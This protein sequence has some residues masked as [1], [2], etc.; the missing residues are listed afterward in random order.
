MRFA[1]TGGSSCTPMDAHTLELLEFAKIR[2]MVAARAACSLGQAA[3]LRVEPS[4]DLG[5]IHHRQ[6]LVTE[7]VEALG[8]GLKPPLGGVHDIGPQVR[9]AQT[10]AVLAAGELALTALCPASDRRHRPLVRADR[11]PVP[12]LGRHE[13]GRG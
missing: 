3:A 12:A 6:S 5:E 4:V 2:A 11:R 7:M 9:R 13:A 1:A 10:G 8:T